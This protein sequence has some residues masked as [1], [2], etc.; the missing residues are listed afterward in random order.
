[1]LDLVEALYSVLYMDVGDQEFVET[2]FR[3]N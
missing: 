2:V 1:M 3:N